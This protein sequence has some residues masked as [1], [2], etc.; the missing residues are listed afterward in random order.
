M[1]KK[2][3]HLTE[4]QLYDFVYQRV[5]E[6]LRSGV[7]EGLWDAIKGGLGKIGG[8]V[9]QGAQNATN[10]ARGAAQNA[11]QGAKNVGNKVATAGQN[12]VQGVKNYANDVKVAGQKASLNADNQKI[13]NQLQQWYQNG[14]FAGSRQAGSAISILINALNKNFNSQYGA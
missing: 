12:A 14:M 1:Q 2:Q 6:A 8:D 5:N 4:S 3:V 9:K 13:A 7:N 11:L 10:Y